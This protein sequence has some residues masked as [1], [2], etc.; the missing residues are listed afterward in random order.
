[1]S[2]QQ[3]KRDIDRLK[4]STGIE[5]LQ[6]LL[7]RDPD[8]L[9]DAEIC[10]LFMKVPVRQLQSN[11]FEVATRRWIASGGTSLSGVSTERLRAILDESH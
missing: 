6:E 5:H 3:V 7:K 2:L 4:E 9:T 11:V 8:I 1:V 10:Q